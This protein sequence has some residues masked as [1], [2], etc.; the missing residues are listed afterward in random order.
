MY[1]LSENEVLAEL[2]TTRDGLS[3]STAKNRLAMQGKNIIEGVK[4]TPKWKKF[5]Y[6]F[7]DL[8]IIILII[9]AIVSLSI[10]IYTKNSEDFI[11]AGVILFVVT[12]RT[13][14]MR[15]WKS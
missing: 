11:D 10:A 6:Q 4:P 15:I 8:L 12:K 7:K 3:S 2:D 1:R 13:K 9:S 14:P 5:L